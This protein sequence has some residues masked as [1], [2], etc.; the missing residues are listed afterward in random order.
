VYLPTQ[1]RDLAAPSPRPKDDRVAE[2][3]AGS[4]SEIEERV[5][6]LAVGARAGR[7]VALPVR[8]SECTFCSVSG[9]CRKPRFAMEPVEDEDLEKEGT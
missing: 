8:E 9:G 2:L 4:P 3:A 6:A 5:V 1:P 7:F